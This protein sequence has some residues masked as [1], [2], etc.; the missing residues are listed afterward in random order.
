[1]NFNRLINYSVWLAFVMLMACSSPV[2]PEIRL[3]PDNAPNVA[4]VREQLD[5]HIDQ[6]VRWGGIILKTDNQQ[7]SSR[8]TVIS[9]PLS[10]KGRPQQSDH[11]TGRFI[12]IVDEFLEPLS[13]SRDRQIT[14][15]GHI[16]RSESEKIGE[17]LYE[18]PVVA[19]DQYYLWPKQVKPVYIDPYPYR[20]Y[21]PWFYR[22]YYPY[23]YRHPYPY[24]LKKPRVKH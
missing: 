9:L 11:S 3:K 17:Y 8:L 4:Q 20:Y 13:F 5:S 15:T 21:D 23:A 7:N 16:V 24:R 12:A 2:P 6:T 1:M 14:V 18:Y 19:V 10:S 22:G